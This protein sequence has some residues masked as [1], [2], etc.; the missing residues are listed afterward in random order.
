M[1]QA[2]ERARRDHMQ[3][4]MVASCL[5]DVVWRSTD[6]SS[7]PHFETDGENAVKTIE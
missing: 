4:P 1:R 5:D 7:L 3:N 2:H 6:V